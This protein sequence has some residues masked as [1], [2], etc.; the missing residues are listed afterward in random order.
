MVRRGGSFLTLFQ[1]IPN[2][3]TQVQF[4]EVHPTLNLGIT[5]PVFW[6]SS[7]IQNRAPVSSYFS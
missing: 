4:H 7:T 6:K 1:Q 5:P 2:F 3:A